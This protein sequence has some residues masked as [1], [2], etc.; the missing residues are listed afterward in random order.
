EPSGEFVLI[1]VANPRRQKRLDRLPEILAKLAPGLAPRRV[2]LV[3]AG[4]PSAAGTDGREA[5]ALFESELERWGMRKA[6]HWT[7]SVDD[8]APL[9]AKADVLISTSEVEGMSLAQLEALAAGLPVVATDVGGAAEIAQRGGR[10]TLLS[11]D[12][13]AEDFVQQLEEIAKTPGS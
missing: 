5:V 7:G 9:L 4:E 1:T 2:K 10:I 11:K 8:V 3:L 6:A 13:P 12:A